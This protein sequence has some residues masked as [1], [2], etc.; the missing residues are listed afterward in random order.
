MILVAMT[1]NTDGRQSLIPKVGDRN[2][3]SVSEVSL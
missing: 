3:V 2:V 1:D